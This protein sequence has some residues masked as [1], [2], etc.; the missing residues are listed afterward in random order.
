MAAIAPGFLCV[1]Q[2]RYRGA[3]NATSPKIALPT[4]GVYGQP[5]RDVL[6]PVAGAT[7]LSPLVPGSPGLEALAAGSLDAISILAPPGTVERR[8]VLA[9]ALRALSPEGRLSVAAPK[10]QGGSRLKK[11]LEAFGCQ[12][13]EDARRHHRILT[14]RRPV[15]PMGLD[16]A[17]ADGSPRLDPKLGLWT[18]PG[19]F[20]WD[21]IDPGSALLVNELPL[22]AGKG[23]DLG[24]GIGFLARTVLTSP[25]VESL[26]LVDLDHRAVE[27]S[28]RNVDDP[29]ASFHWADI[30]S[31]GIAPGS[32]DFAVTNPPFHDTGNEDRVLGQTFIRQAAAMLRKGG[33]LWLVANRHLPYEVVLDEVFKTWTPHGDTGAYKVIEARK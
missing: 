25:R 21:R 18:W 31:T 22:L 12:P 27:A 4:I 11:E 5:P 17:I 13:A 30:R 3:V 10:D 7:Q 16:K 1:G 9:Q 14:C 20:S 15:V 29:R 6:E 33:A 26:A 32:L 28:K 23:A 19:V 8:Y 2:A 24:S